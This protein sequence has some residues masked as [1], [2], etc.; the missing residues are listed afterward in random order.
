MCAND[1]SSIIVM[2]QQSTVVV[3]IIALLSFLFVCYTSGILYQ[4]SSET[5]ALEKESYLEV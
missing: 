2:V 3:V 5:H 4:P 1:H